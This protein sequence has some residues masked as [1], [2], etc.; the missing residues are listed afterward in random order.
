[1][2]KWEMGRAF[3]TEKDK[4]TINYEELVSITT[5]CAS[6]HSGNESEK[7]YFK[8]VTDSD[9]AKTTVRSNT[10]RG[11]RGWGRKR[12]IQGKNEILK[13]Y[14]RLNLTLFSWYSFLNWKSTLIRKYKINIFYILSSFQDISDWRCHSKLGLIFF[15]HEFLK[16]IILTQLIEKWFPILLLT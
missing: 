2:G 5:E 6:Q 9:F 7:D 4:I 12:G 14:T 15:K 3:Q 1:M 16:Y 11:L 8:A 13:I 10:E